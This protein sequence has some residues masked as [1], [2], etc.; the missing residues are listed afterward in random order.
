MKILSF[1][2][3]LRQIYLVG[4]DMQKKLDCLSY[5]FAYRIVSAFKHANH[6]K[7]EQL[8]EKLIKRL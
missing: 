3:N 5:F 2:R 8:S 6:Q 1:V 4:N 7:I